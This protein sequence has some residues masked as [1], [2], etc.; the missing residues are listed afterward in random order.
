MTAE[1][2]TPRPPFYPD[3]LQRLQ[4]AL[5]QTSPPNFRWRLQA[6]L[7]VAQGQNFAET[8]RQFHV[9]GGTV[10]QWVDRYFAAR[11]IKDLILPPTVA[12]L[13]LEREDIERLSSALQRV[14]RPRERRRLRAV[15]DVA[16]GLGFPDAAQ[17]AGVTAKAVHLWVA[18]YLQH[19]RIEDV[20]TLKQ[21]TR[22]DFQRGD[23]LTLTRA[24][25]DFTDPRA[26]RRLRVV[27]A[28][29]QGMGIMDAA[30]AFTV[31]KDSIA[32]WIRCFLRRHRAEDLLPLKP[33]RQSDA[34]IDACLHPETLI[35]NRYL[36]EQL[37]QLSRQLPAPIGQ[38]ELARR[39]GV[40][41]QYVHHLVQDGRLPY[42]RHDG[43]IVFSPFALAVFQPG[44]P[45]KRSPTALWSL[46]EAAARLGITVDTVRHLIKTRGYRYLRIGHSKIFFRE[47]DL[48][49][50][51][52]S[53][54]KGQPWV[55]PEPP[56]GAVQR[57]IVEVLAA[58]SGSLRWSEI[59]DRGG[60]PISSMRKGF[61][62]LIDRGR[63]VRDEQGK[64]CLAPAVRS[65]L[66][67][68]RST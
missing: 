46:G 30:R 61:Y 15:L 68:S 36:R 39:L 59:R 34:L 14:S 63:I 18:C 53:Y 55:R 43:V 24:L 33:G 5:A 49:A 31:H 28:V 12:R 41:R 65:M 26:V 21:G 56:L 57:R 6:V 1:K 20:L 52:R 4:E 44:K 19:R 67:F 64:Y 37:A 48:R 60:I 35:R 17:H 29:A 3:D 9:S 38:S 13:G 23:L 22:L 47:P 16:K 66:Q 32:K 58:S 45:R 2:R 11:Q 50:I 40:S 62:A 25:A 8:G 10:R 42:T 54:Q 27:R 51:E 7:A